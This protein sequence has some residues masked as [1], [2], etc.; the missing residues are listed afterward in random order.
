MWCPPYVLFCCC[1]VVMRLARIMCSSYQA[2]IYLFIFAGNEL[3][4]S[5][6]IMPLLPP[7]KLPAPNCHQEPNILLSKLVL[8]FPRACSCHSARD[9]WVAYCEVRGFVTEE[10]PLR[11]S[12]RC[13]AYHVWFTFKC[14]ISIVFIFCKLS[15]PPVNWLLRRQAG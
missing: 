4:F 8:Q 11:S 13:A 1:R 5:S 6:Y 15:P 2:Y 10:S 9:C 12:T 3:M 7:H 14:Y